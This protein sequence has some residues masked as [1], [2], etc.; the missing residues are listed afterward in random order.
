MGA[1]YFTGD[2]VEQN[3]SEGVKWLRKSAE[4]GYDEAQFRL[5]VM[6]VNG[7]HIEKDRKEGVKWLKKAAR[8]GHVNAIKLLKVMGESQPVLK[9]HPGASG[10]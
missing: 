9:G 5:G 2:G 6:Y 3:P 8:Q 1:I 10:H 4:K 7:D